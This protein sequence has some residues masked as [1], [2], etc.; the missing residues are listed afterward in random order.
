MTT[1]ARAPLVIVYARARGRWRRLAG[2][3][4][5]VGPEGDMGRLVGCRPTQGLKVFLI[6]K[7]YNLYDSNLNSNSNLN[8]LK[9]IQKIQL[10]TLAFISPNI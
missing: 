3:R 6:S 10:L 2:V 9:Q 1:S 5:S 7:L 4:A 8:P